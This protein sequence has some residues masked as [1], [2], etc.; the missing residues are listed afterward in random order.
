M[1]IEEF[2]SEL[3]ITTIRNCDVV[4]LDG[5]LVVHFNADDGTVYNAGLSLQDWLDGHDDAWVMTEEEA[6][7]VG[8][9]DYAGYKDRLQQLN[10]SLFGQANAM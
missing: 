7:R 8:V 6:A 9:V 3:D 1:K 4:G 2:D 10:P 5:E